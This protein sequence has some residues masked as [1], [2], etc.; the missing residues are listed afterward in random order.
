MGRKEGEAMHIHFSLEL[1][2]ATLGWPNYYL[3]T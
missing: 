2:L 3:L 1:T